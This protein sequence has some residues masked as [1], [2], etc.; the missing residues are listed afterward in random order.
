MIFPIKFSNKDKFPIFLE[1]SIPWGKSIL[2]FNDSPF[3]IILIKSVFIFSIVI[4]KLFQFPYLKFFEISMGPES[5]S[6]KITNKLFSLINWTLICFSPIMK[7]IKVIVLFIFLPP[8]M[9]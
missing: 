3:I 4:Q 7:L 2:H 8:F 1:K 9:V 5:F 6:S